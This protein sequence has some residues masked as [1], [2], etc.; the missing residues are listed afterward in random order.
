MK[1]SASEFPVVRL[2]D[3]L[4]DLAINR[5]ASDIHF[6]PTAAQLRVRLRIDGI[7]YDHDPVDMVMTQQLVARLKVLANI[8]IAEKR[9]P[10]DGKFRI[11]TH[12]NEIDLRVST[13]PALYGEKVVVRILDRADYT[14]SLDTLGLSNSMSEE[15]KAIIGKPNGFFLVCGPTGSGKT[16]TLYAA[17]T[18][19]NNPEKHI[20]TLE[21]PIEYSIDGITQAQIHP[22]AG[23]TFEKGIRALLRQDPD[24][25]MIGEIRDKQ[26]AAIAIEASLTGH[27]VFSTV[28]TNDAPSVVMRLMDMGIEPFLINASLSGILAQRLVRKLCCVC[29]YQAVV[30]SQEQAVLH[31][32]GADGITSLFKAR[33]CEQC[34]WL[35]Y[36][37]R[38]GLFEL[39]TMSN[40]LRGLIVKSPSFSDISSQARSDGMTTLLADGISKVKEGVVSLSELLRVAA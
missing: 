29:K 3:N 18:A 12:G 24:V 35:G 39:L 5:S 6:E 16:T 13:F 23:F 11:I 8:N 33:G 4:L 27:Q 26:T 1:A 40:Q 7:L 31:R 34:L 17:L 20:V 2:V 38:V 30:D 28:H 14:M 22:D 25:V 19:L 21:D 15:I 32:L 10:Q 37:G 9:I 36:K